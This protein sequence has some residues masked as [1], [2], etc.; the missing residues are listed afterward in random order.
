M[1]RGSV[2]NEWS[3]RDY[4]RGTQYADAQRLSARAKL[5]YTYSNATTPWFEWLA[6][7]VAWPSSGDVL[8]VGCGPGAMWVECGDVVPA[9]LRLTLS[10]F[11]PGMVQ[12]AA[13]RVRSVSPNNVVDALEA[14]VQDL[15]FADE[16]FD[17]VVANHMLYHVPDPSRA[18]SEIA[19]VLRPRGRLLAATNG[20]RNLRE[21]GEITAA[22]LGGVV[23]EDPAGPFGAV[24]GLAI[25]RA[26]FGEVEWRPFYDTLYCTDADDVLAHI[27]SHPPGENATT[28]QLEA[29][30]R[31]IQERLDAGG[32][33]LVVFKEAGA[34]VA[35]R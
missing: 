10:D 3:D 1:G 20:P 29:L 23:I 17:V 22:A 6:S 31:T 9:D 21:L 18:V 28:A 11:A 2:P 8:E 33:T 35:T 32:G 5:H 27:T 12:L 13:Q 7:Q 24:S 19:R 4:L 34:F 16:T 26:H 15:P 30:R 25:L 14:D